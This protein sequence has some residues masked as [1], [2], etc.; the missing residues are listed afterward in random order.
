MGQTTPNM[1][2]YI[3]AAGETNY[4]ASFAAGMINIDQHNHSGAPN[5]GVP[6]SGAGIAAG[7]ITYDKLNANVVTSGGGLQVN[8]AFPN[9]L[10]VAGFL[11]GLFALSSTGIVVQTGANTA[12]DRTLVGSTNQIAIANPSGVSGNPTFTLAPVVLNPT[13]PL[14]SAYL[15]TDQNSVTGDGTLYTI[16]CDTAVVNQGAYYNT[17][18]GVFTAPIAGNYFFTATTLFVAPNASGT[19]SFINTIVASSPAYTFEGRMD[20]ATSSN[21]NIAV[22]ATNIIPLAL[23]ATVTLKALAS[24]GAKTTNIVSVTGST[25]RTYFSGYLV[26]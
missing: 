17:G 20:V 22:T 12:V 24:G 7:A 14:F 9:Q 21:T 5:E 15:S 2:I 16:V 18:T 3:P 25:V 10:E 19:V 8:G 6:I 26:C 1:G 4:D 13:Q 23:G 11:T